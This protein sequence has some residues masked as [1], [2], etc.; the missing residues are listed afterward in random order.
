METADAIDELMA[1]FDSAETGMECEHCGFPVEDVG[2]PCFVCGKL[3]MNRSMRLTTLCQAQ[4]NYAEDGAEKDDPTDLDFQDNDS[5][6]G[7]PGVYNQ[8]STPFVSGGIKKKKKRKKACRRIPLPK[9]PLQAEVQEE[10]ELVLQTRTSL[11]SKGSG[12]TVRKFVRYQ[13]M[14]FEEGV[15]TCRNDFF[16]E[17]ALEKAH[18]FYRKVAL[19]KAEESPSCTPA[20]KY[21]SNMVHGFDDYVRLVNETCGDMLDM[22]FIDGILSPEPKEMMDKHRVETPIAKKM[23]AFDRARARSCNR[24]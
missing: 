8:S 12:S 1:I 23:S 24:E 19:K 15:F 3:V 5:I 2:L 17:G 22:D 13:A 18:E 6:V 7:D 4:I 16:A 9:D 11:N 14:L 10:F 21:F 20:A